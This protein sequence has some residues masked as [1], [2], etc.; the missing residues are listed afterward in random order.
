[1]K[2][3]YH[4]HHRIRVTVVMKKDLQVWLWFLEDFNG[5]SIWR[6]E[7]WQAAELQGVWEF[8]FVGIGIQ[9]H[10]QMLGSRRVGLGTSHSLNSSPL[11]SRFRF[12]GMTWPIVPCIFGVT[13]WQLF[14]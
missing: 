2:G 12:G 4:P 13:I 3:A 6:E 1:M 11:W 10:G 9:N 5:I 8:S 14:R 7:L